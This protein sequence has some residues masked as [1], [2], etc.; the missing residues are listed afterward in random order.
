MPVM[1]PMEP[2]APR[3]LPVHDSLALLSFPAPQGRVG[4]CGEFGA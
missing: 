4:A 2:M 3:T 1:E